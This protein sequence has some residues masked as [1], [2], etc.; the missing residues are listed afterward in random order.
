MGNSRTPLIGCLP[1][2]GNYTPG[3][4]PGP[5]GRNDAAD[6]NAQICIAADTPGPVGIGGDVGEQL[7]S[8]AMMFCEMNVPVLSV[9]IEKMR[10]ILYTVAYAEAADQA[11]TR[12]FGSAEISLGDQNQI[13]A[14][15]RHA[16]D[17]LMEE[18]V[19][20]M[21]MGPESVRSFI[22]SQEGRKDRA[23][24]SLKGKLD[25]AGKVG[26]NWVSVLG[27]V[28]KGLS[29]L[30]FGSTVTIKTLSLFTGHFG[31][32]IDIAYSGAQEGIKQA[33]SGPEDKTVMGVVVD[34]TL[35]SGLQE[36]AGE[37]NEL[38]AKGIM[39]Q[40]EKNR[41]DGLLGNYKGNA[42]KLAEQIADLEARLFKAMKKQAGAKA[43]YPEAQ[44]AK[45]LAKLRALRIQTARSLFG[46]GASGLTKKAAGH[47]LSVVFLAEEVKEAW[48]EVRSEWRG[49]N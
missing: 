6:P 43:A 22:D 49:S 20:A 29:G 12:G 27:G 25:D 35:E 19:V 13:E 48:G 37:L 44:Y 4:S 11:A 30:K 8:N 14:M 23:R 1:L 21:E 42:K 10:R 41:F 3:R 40:A 34:E 2:P 18:L 9:D 31:T 28:V 24:A 32:A 47:T 17:Q 26:K 36:L 7:C 5:L 39:T 46:K 45:K 38:V 16:A 33:Q 15:A